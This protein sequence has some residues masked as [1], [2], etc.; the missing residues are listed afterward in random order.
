MEKNQKVSLGC[1]SL[2][3]IALIVLIFSNGNQD[4]LSGQVERL[5]AEVRNLQSAVHEQSRQIRELRAS[6]AASS[7]RSDGDSIPR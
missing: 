4:E 3:L 7:S 6:L 5:S 2:I 1:G